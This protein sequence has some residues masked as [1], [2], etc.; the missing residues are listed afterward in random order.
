MGRQARDVAGELE[1]WGLSSLPMPNELTRQLLAAPHSCGHSTV[2]AAKKR[3]D[4]LSM[5]LSITNYKENRASFRDRGWPG[6][7]AALHW[8]SGVDFAP[9]RHACPVDRA[10]VIKCSSGSHQDVPIAKPLHWRSWSRLIYQ[11]C[12]EQHCIF[13]AVCWGFIFWQVAHVWKLW[14]ALDAF[15]NVLGWAVAVPEN[16]HDAPPKDV[17]GGGGWVQSSFGTFYCFI[18]NDILTE[19]L[20]KLLLGDPNKLSLLG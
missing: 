3:G 5:V 16:L 11:F 10:Q 20:Q 1:G 9:W 15:S 18:P 19:A 8:I 2:A 6:H 7:S 13:K 4:Y 17:D 14:D 12:Q